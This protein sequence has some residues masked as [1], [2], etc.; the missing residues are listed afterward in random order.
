MERYDYLAIGE[1]KFPCT[2]EACATI[3]NVQTGGTEVPLQTEVCAMR[4]A[5]RSALADLQIESVETSLDA[6]DR[7][8]LRHDVLAEDLT[9]EGEESG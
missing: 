4:T 3:R 2:L 1:L 7:S 8:V 6:A 5:S 9:K